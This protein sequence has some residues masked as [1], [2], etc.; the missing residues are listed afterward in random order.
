MFVTS[1]TK[2][3]N[4]KFFIFS[5]GNRPIFIESTLKECVERANSILAGVDGSS[6]LL[7]YS[8]VAAAVKKDGGFFG[9]YNIS[10]IMD[11]PYSVCLIG[12]PS[13][14]HEAIYSAK[15]EASSAS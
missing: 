5:I 1:L 3:L 7:K 13:F 4:M 12:A 14:V 2:Q 9:K 11:V 6:S 8:T 15:K 10:N